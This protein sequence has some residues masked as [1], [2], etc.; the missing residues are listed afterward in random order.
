MEHNLFFF[1]V[2]IVQ[3]IKGRFVYIKTHTSSCC[4]VLYMFLICINNRFTLA[5][6]QV[7]CLF[8]GAKISHVNRNVP[9]FFKNLMVNNKGLSCCRCRR[10]CVFSPPLIGVRSA[11][12][13]RELLFQCL[14]LAR[15]SCSHSAG[16]CVWWFFF[17]MGPLGLKCVSILCLSTPIYPPSEKRSRQPDYIERKPVGGAV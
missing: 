1:S 3:H 7:S 14:D 2:S 10:C 16:S 15:N 6:T 17:P 11:L 8:F 4:D 12:L 9:L 13:C 5:K